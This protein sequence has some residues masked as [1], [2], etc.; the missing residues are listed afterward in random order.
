[1][2]HEIPFSDREVPVEDAE[3]LSFHTTNIFL[4]ENARPPSPSR[5]FDGVI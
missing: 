4:G 3:E 1:M 2:S 5:V